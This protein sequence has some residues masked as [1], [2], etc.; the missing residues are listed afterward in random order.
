MFKNV[1]IFKSFFLL[2][3]TKSFLYFQFYILLAI[4]IA[5]A[6]AGDGTVFRC[7]LFPDFQSFFL[8]I[9]VIPP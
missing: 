6:D 1:K 9:S 7:E 8:F 4:Y 2:D 5:S 3:R